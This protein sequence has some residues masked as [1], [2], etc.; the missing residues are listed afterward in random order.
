MSSIQSKFFYGLLKIFNAKKLIN[1]SVE[2]GKRKNQPFFS[3]AEK[4]KYDILVER[5]NQKE[6]SIMGKDR[7]IKHHLVYFH[8]GMYIAEGNAGHKR[9]L[10][11]L[12]NQGNCKISYIDYPLA[13]E[14]TYLETVEMVVK[15]Y[16]FLITQYPRDKF[17]LM[18]DSAGGGLALILAQHLRN[19]GVEHRPVKLILYS[20]WVRLDMTNPDIQKTS[21][22]DVILDLGM[23]Q[24]SAR[25]YAGKDDLTNEYLSPYYESCKNLEEIHVFYGTDE[26]LA[27]DILLLKDKC[28]EEN[29]SARFYGYE[30]MQHDFQLFTFLPESKDVLNRTIKIITGF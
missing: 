11:N 18:G 27:A 16:Q 23:L 17:I 20:P 3:E 29:A 9:W 10:I 19:N 21:H 15:A 7:E 1:K 2:R 13:P 30:G 24:K 6:V 25:V 12:F 22:K 26:M 5:I 28:D 14:H 4:K 8:G